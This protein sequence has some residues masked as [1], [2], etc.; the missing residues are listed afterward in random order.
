L[1]RASM[2][3]NAAPHPVLQSY[4]ETRSN[5]PDHPDKLSGPAATIKG[6]GKLPKDVLRGDLS[7][8]AKLVFA[9]LS[10]VERRKITIACMVKLTAYGR[11]CFLAQMEK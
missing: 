5:Y 4:K 8:A 9:T 10:P 6:W 7:P 11:K 2:R 3:S 1:R